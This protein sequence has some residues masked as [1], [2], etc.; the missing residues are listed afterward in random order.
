MQV[1]KAFFKIA[2]KRLNAAVIY[3]LIYAAITVLLSSTSEDNY[4]SNF[5][6]SQL[7]V[8]V[9]D[10]DESTASKALCNYLSSLH[11]VT[12]QA[13]D[14][15]TVLDQIYY[16]TLD[17][18]L[19]IPAG[20][21]DALLSGDSE[22]ILTSLTIPGSTR[23]QYVD[24]QISQYLQSIQIYLAGG[25]TLAEAIE[26]TDAAVA[27]APEVAVISFREATS[28]SNSAVFYFF[29][30]LPYIFIAILFT[31]MAPIL[32]VLGD[33]S[34]KDRTACSALPGR[35]RTTS[36]MAGCTLYSL[37]LWLL[38]LLLGF[39][40]YGKD[41]L[42]TT[43]L[44]AIL[45]SFV[46]LLFAAAA[47]LLLSSFSPDDNVLN[48]IAN[49]FGLSMSFLCGIF[50]PQSMLPDSVLSVGRFLPAY[51]YVRINNML[52]GFGKEIFDSHFYWQCIGI[53]LLFAIAVFVLIPVAN[54]QKRRQS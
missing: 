4:T 32:V 27:A 31:G 28:Q 10:N 40:L 11:H 9:T 16:R 29:Q 43:V 8:T 35:V 44:Y 5:Q 41:M 36:L 12:K 34:I 21:E 47:T 17:Y 19:T 2:K 53:E 46:F 20:F 49:I 14:K 23:G 30:Y 26:K 39:I 51:W 42:Q 1:F 22:E 38:F 37:G 33:R 24:Q 18:A 25:S 13:E 7:Y 54:R 3:F 45:N 6:S 50:V 52:G 48:M 15:N